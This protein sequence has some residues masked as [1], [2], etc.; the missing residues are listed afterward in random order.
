[1]YRPGQ[2]SFVVL[3]IGCQP[4]DAFNLAD[5][6]RSAVSQVYLLNP[7]TDTKLYSSSCVGVSCFVP[8]ADTADSLLDRAQQAL[9]E[10]R[11]NGAGQLVVA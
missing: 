4:Q 6:L 5:S 10:A 7:K 11:C 9:D 8:E 2:D 3:A 1:M